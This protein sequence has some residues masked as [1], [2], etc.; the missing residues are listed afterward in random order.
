MIRKRQNIDAIKHDMPDSLFLSAVSFEERCLN[1]SRL[2]S[3]NYVTEEFILIRYRGADNDHKRNAHQ[4]EL[5]KNLTSHSGREEKGTVIHCD[6]DDSIDGLVKLKEVL[7]NR[8]LSEGRITIDIT[9]FTKQYLLVLLK[10]IRQDYPSASIRILYT[11]GYYEVSSSHPEKTALS[12]GVKEIKPVPGFL[13]N[14]LPWQDDILVLFLGYEG[15]RAFQIMQKLEPKKTIAVLPSPPSYP[16]ADRPTYTLNKRILSRPIDEV[17]RYEADALDPE[18][19]RDLLLELSKKYED[20]ERCNLIISPICT[21]IQTLGILLFFWTK[22]DTNAQV[23][24]TLPFWYNEK[25]YTSGF[26]NHVLEYII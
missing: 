19:T 1:S 22:K 26:P 24:Y 20:E 8:D 6:K 2:L 16:H 5:F 10:S 4:N 7:K 21:K 17:E 14:C 13:G 18:S 9:T 15:E 3:D 11:P 12:W 25:K 23:I